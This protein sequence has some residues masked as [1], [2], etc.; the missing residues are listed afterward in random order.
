MD[1]LLT[2]KQWEFKNPLKCEHYIHQAQ[3][4]TIYNTDQGSDKSVCANLT[5]TSMALENAKKPK[6][7]NKMYN[8][9]NCSTSSDLI[10]LL[11]IKFWS[12]I[13][14]LPLEHHASTS[15]STGAYGSHCQH[16]WE[17]IIKQK[18]SHVMLHAYGSHCE[19]AQEN[20]LKQK[21]PTEFTILMI[22]PLLQI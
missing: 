12:V 8:I 10:L 7:T 1:L 20:L 3:Q 21:W 11:R 14:K 17:N 2:S 22:I 5:R 16:M 9:N 18:R 6:T 19:L 4:Q 15:I 13:G